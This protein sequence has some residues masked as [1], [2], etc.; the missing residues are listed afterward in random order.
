MKNKR[1]YKIIAE[2]VRWLLKFERLDHKKLAELPEAQWTALQ[3]EASDWARETFG[4]LSRDGTPLGLP[5]REDVQRAHFRVMDLMGH[6]RRGHAWETGVIR[7]N[8]TLVFDAKAGRFLRERPGGDMRWADVFLLQVYES[9]T[10]LDKA[11]YRFRFCLFCKKPFVGEG[12]QRYCLGH[13]ARA[14]HVRYREANR[15]QIQ[16]R[17]KDYYKTF[18]ADLTGI[19]EE[20]VTIRP[21]RRKSDKAQAT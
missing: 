11:G 5:T 3:K 19:P 14:R 13:S 12:K 10:D 8:R 18:K 16:K 1:R 20:E 15:E 9:L 4:I 2:R 7:T 21:Y 6:F 17:R